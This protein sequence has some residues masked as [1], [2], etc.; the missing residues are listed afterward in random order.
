ME[1]NDEKMQY[2]C[3]IGLIEIYKDKDR[4]YAFSDVGMRPLNNYE[5]YRLIKRI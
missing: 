5:A 2:V 1:Y 4:Y 3:T